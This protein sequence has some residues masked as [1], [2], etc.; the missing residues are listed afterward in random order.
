MVRPAERDEDERLGSPPTDRVIAIVELLATQHQPSSVA[1]I[2]SR[3]E[4]NRATVTSILLA[5]ERAGWALRQADRKY[6]LGPGLVGVADAVR[7]L[8]PLSNEFTNAIEELAERAGCGAALALVGD[9]E[10][11]FLTV[12]RGRGRIPAGVDV[13]VRLPLVAP[14]AAAVIAHHDAQAQ[15]MWLASA[16][17][18]SR[19]ALDDVLSQA[20]QSGVVVFGLGGAAD[21][22]ALD[23]LAEVVELLA[24]HPRRAALR[25]RVFG[26]L[27]GLNGNPYTAAELATSQALSV[28]YLTAPVFNTGQA[29]YE[30]QLGPLRGAVSAPERNR[31]IR[32]IRATA[33]KLSS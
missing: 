29:V 22:E 24:E 31:Y 5:L 18:D 11:S 23:V 21:P 10:L 19:E 26:L 4:L 16:Q 17:N 33:E 9:T 2:S 3:L 1:S 6:T 14:V 8:L 30:L 32:E 12:V 25:Q 27:A 7:Q 13:G 28:S 15:R 20:R